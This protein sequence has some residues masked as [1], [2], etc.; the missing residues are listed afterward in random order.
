MN[1]EIGDVGGHRLP[2][3]IVRM[4]EHAYDAKHPKEARRDAKAGN[5]CGHLRMVV[6][7]TCPAWVPDA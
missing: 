5:A 6:A 2:D 1:A 4:A 3:R 7:T